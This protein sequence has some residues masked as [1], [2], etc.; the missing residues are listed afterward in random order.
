M[1][2]DDYQYVEGQ[3]DNA[4]RS[5]TNEIKLLTHAIGS[6]RKIPTQVN[7]VAM[8]R[9]LKVLSFSQLTDL[10]GDIPYSQAGLAFYE[11]VFHPVFDTQQSIYADMLKELDEAASSMK[12][13]A[14]YGQMLIY[15]CRRCGEMEEICLLPDASTGHACIQCRCGHATNM[16]QSHRRWSCYQQ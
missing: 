13:V 16:W 12:P 6:F 15:Q 2:G 3:N 10:Y 11:G 1:P 5:Y 14:K 4:W 8:C 7:N 9:I